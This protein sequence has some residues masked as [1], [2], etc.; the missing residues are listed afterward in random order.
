M[1]TRDIEAV[2]TILA[3]ATGLE[4]SYAYDDLIFPEH[5]A[6]ILQFD[7]N[8]DNGLICHFNE[9]SPK[10]DRDEIYNS[11]GTVCAKYKCSLSREGVFSMKPKGE[12]LELT[13]TKESL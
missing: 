1:K 5:S 6:F 4:V 3:E 2:R 8:V 12:E 10:A 13:F 11:L 9:E 7:E